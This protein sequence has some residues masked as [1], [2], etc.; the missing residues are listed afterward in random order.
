[1]ELR[2]LSAAA[3]ALAIA[4]CNSSTEPAPTDKPDAPTSPASDID[5]LPDVNP[6]APSQTATARVAAGKAFAENMKDSVGSVLAA[7]DIIEQFASNMQTDIE[8]LGDEDVTAL[9]AI[10]AVLEDAIDVQMAPVLEPVADTSGTYTMLD[11]SAAAGTHGFANL[12][13]E[14]LAIT[15]SNSSNWQLVDGG[16]TGTWKISLAADVVQTC[17]Q[18]PSC[19]P[20]EHKVE[21]SFD[22]T[23][24]SNAIALMEMVDA[25]DT[26]HA[27]D[28]VAGSVNYMK[29]TAGRLAAESTGAQLNIDF[30]DN[31]LEVKRFAF[32]IDETTLTLNNIQISG[33]ADFSVTGNNEFGLFDD[34]YSQD[35][36]TDANGIVTE[37][38]EWREQLDATYAATFS[39]MVSNSAGDKWQAELSAKGVYKYTTSSNS[40]YV[41]DS[42]DYWY[43]DSDS[44]WQESGLIDHEMTASTELLVNDNSLK[45]ATT[46][47]LEIAE[48]EGQDLTMKALSS[49]TI[50]HNSNVFAM[51]LDLSGGE[52]QGVNAALW[53]QEDDGDLIVLRFEDDHAWQ[54]DEL[55]MGSLLVNG[56]VVA[57]LVLNDANGTVQV[58]FPGEEPFILLDSM[59]LQGV[60]AEPY[61]DG[62][63][64]IIVEPPVVY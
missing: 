35:S 57:P 45:I 48:L 34:Y 17:D 24:P 46:S 54:G 61:P 32:N 27:V 16:D 23:L 26:T 42:N 33:S 59:L 20:Y 39:G 6:N 52:T 53:Q 13:D 28:S 15:Y 3:L 4:G 21:L 55:R 30:V 58:N 1:M 19:T 43:I 22:V 31:V 29:L 11:F 60:T 18:Q 12:Q 8:Q 5:G 50:T 41:Y 14:N 44:T 51:G 2:I 37:T 7:E 25:E 63:T 38:S 49:L 40:T 64:V 47:K 36:T 9:Q 56:E 10:V 62:N